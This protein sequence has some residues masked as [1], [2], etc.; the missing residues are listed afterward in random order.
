MRC[1]IERD[2]SKIDW[3]YFWNNAKR[4]GYE[5]LYLVVFK[6]LKEYFLFN[7]D[8]FIINKDVIVNMETVE[9]FMNL[10]CNI[11]NENNSDTLKYKKD[12]ILDKEDPINNT[13]NESFL[14]NIF[15]RFQKQ[16]TVTQS[17]ALE[18]ISGD[19]SNI[20]KRKELLLSLGVQI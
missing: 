4:Q 1:I 9:Q 16:E 14:K 19:I 11:D 17:C 2:N 7:T 20:D 8:K 13:A 10:L 6:I 18:N 5:K 15:K 3:E 12:I